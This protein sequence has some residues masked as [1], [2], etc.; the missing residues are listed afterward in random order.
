[1]GVSCQIIMVPCSDLVGLEYPSLPQPMG[2]GSKLEPESQK[3][4]PESRLNGWAAEG[5][6]VQLS[7][8]GTVTGFGHR[9]DWTIAT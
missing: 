9:S 5:A 6:S 2:Q 3:R 8:D 7:C 4:D 1:M